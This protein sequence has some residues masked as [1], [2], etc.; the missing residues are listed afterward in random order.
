MCSDAD[1]EDGSDR[2]AVTAVGA[3][4]E[5]ATT[6]TMATTAF[7]IYTPGLSDL[8]LFFG[9]LTLKFSLFQPMIRYSQTRRRRVIEIDSEDEQGKALVIFFIIYSIAC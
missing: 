4:A 7:C 1:D 9:G 6:T 3:A 5:A 8:N 2:T